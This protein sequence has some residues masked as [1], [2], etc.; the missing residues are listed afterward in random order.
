M[1]ICI[2]KDGKV[3]PMYENHFTEMAKKEAKELQTIDNKLRED[4]PELFEGM[5]RWNS[6][7]WMAEGMSSLIGAA[8]KFGDGSIYI[9]I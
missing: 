4:M 7:Q 9:D 2:Y 3:I 5:P 6:V 8:E 1:R